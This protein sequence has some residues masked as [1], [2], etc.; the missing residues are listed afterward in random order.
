[1]LLIGQLTMPSNGDLEGFPHPTIPAVIGIPTYE[2]ISKVNLQLN[3]NAASVHSNLGNGAH[4]LL[5]LMINPAVFNTLS[6][7]P[8]IIP[9]NPDAQPIFPP[10]ATA[11]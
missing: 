4:E 1:M 8:F 5:A 11:T 7:V 9:A 2:T 6:A 3:T 10:G